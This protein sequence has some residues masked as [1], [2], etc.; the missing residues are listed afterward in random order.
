MLASVLSNNEF[1]GLAHIDDLVEHYHHHI[2]EHKEDI[3]FLEF[4]AMH[5]LDQNHLQK[6][7]QEHESLPLHSHSAHCLTLNFI[8][9]VNQTF[10]SIRTIVY[11]E[12]ISFNS[13]YIEHFFSTPLIDIWQPPKLG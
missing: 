4:L 7:K 3:N 6:D 11:H 13:Y 2:E 12:D 5:Y 10:Q 8:P 9:S 1:A